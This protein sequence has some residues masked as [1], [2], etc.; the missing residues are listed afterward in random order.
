MLLSYSD[1]V[2]MN[3]PGFTINWPDKLRS[4]QNSTVTI[5]SG[6]SSAATVQMYTLNDH[7]N[8]E[9]DTRTATHEILVLYNFLS[10]KIFEIFAQNWSNRTKM[11]EFL[12]R[13]SH[14]KTHSIALSNVNQVIDDW[15]L[16]Y[17]E[18]SYKGIGSD[19]GS[20]ICNKIIQGNRYVYQRRSMARA[21]RRTKRKDIFYKSIVFD[22]DGKITDIKW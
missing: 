13:A 11:E 3:L 6:V 7:E 15:I 17:S 2:K 20:W 5:D 22:E 1:V 9:L 12:E 8:G 16:I 10:Q 14:E 4:K 21:Q 19:L 18:I